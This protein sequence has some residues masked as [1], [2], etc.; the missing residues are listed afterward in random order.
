[1]TLV[2][3]DSKRTGMNMTLYTAVAVALTV[4]VGPA[5]MTQMS[6]LFV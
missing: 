4:A 1:M 3:Y 6:A 2:A 5:C